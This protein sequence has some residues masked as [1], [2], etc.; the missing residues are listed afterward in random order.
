MAQIKNIHL[1]NNQVKQIDLDRMEH[2]ALQ[3]KRY[4]N[5]DFK[6]VEYGPK[7]LIIQIAQGKNAGGNYFDKKR[8]IEIVHETFDRFFKDH[9]IHVHPIEY[10]DSKANKVDSKWIQ[11]K[12]LS[13]EIKLKEIA[14]DTGI[15]Y[16]QLSSLVSGDRPLSQPMKALFWY[17]FSYKEIMADV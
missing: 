12:M 11:D 10:I 17:Y 13:G 16:T 15:D 9:K 7:K 4:S 8:L 2:A 5:L 1:L 6:I 3:H 14:A